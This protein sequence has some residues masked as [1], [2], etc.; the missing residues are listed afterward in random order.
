[1]FA[2]GTSTIWWEASA[3]SKYRTRCNGNLHTPM[4]NG[5]GSGCSRPHR[6]AW[7]RDLAGA[8]DIICMKRCDNELL[9]RPR[10]T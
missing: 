10:E 2:N 4:A 7:T 5:A 6:S 8:G 3:G 1:M 9:K